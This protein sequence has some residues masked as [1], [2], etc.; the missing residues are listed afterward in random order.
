V[1]A[2][3]SADAGAALSALVDLIADAVVQRLKGAEVA[4][5]SGAQAPS[6]WYNQDT[7]P[8]ARRT[9]L[10]LCRSGRVEGRRVGKMV[11]VR[12][13]VL[14]AWILTHGTERTAPTS[15]TP[16]ATPTNEELM[17]AAGFRRVAAVPVETSPASG[18]RR[19]AGRRKK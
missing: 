6:S 11:L 7:S 15:P 17:R 16:T 12:R 3:A 8:L 14:D 13:D 5:G 10:A 4:P 19:Q 2:H 1:S 18:P 9:Y